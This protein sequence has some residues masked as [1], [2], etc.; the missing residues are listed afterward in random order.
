MKYSG[1]CSF[2]FFSPFLPPPPLLFPVHTRGCS[3]TIAECGS[4]RHQWIS[5]LQNRSSL[6]KI[7]T[8]FFLEII[9]MKGPF[10]FF[11]PLFFPFF[12]F[13]HILFLALNLFHHLN[14]SNNLCGHME[15]KNKVKYKACLIVILIYIPF[16]F[17][18]LFLPFFFPPP[19]SRPSHAQTSGFFTLRR[20]LWRKHNHPTVM[21][22]F[23]QVAVDVSFP[24]LILPPFL[25]FLEYTLFKPSML[26]QI[27]N[28]GDDWGGLHAPGG[29]NIPGCKTH[30]I[31]P[32]FFPSPLPFFS[33]FP[34]QNCSW[35]MFL[36]GSSRANK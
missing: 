22:L 34:P 1:G 28:Q 7:W 26:S 27:P 19:S 6:P 24:P 23:W 2:F 36:L 16:F 14:K 11:F 12:F 18:P 4:A 21:H 35:L 3:I 29:G 13:D 8:H 17:P 9:R 5:G 33:P 25:F 30:E 32:L 31:F 20:Y 10:L 15:E